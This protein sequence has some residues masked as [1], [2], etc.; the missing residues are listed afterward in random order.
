MMLDIAAGVI[1]GGAIFTKRLDGWC[2][3]QARLMIAAPE[4]V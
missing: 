1:I 3:S 4:F 2:L